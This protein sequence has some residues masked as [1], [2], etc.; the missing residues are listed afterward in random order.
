MF[1]PMAQGHG[2]TH[3]AQHIIMFSLLDSLSANKPHPPLKV[4][5]CISKWILKRIFILY[6]DLKHIDQIKVY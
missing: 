6:S 4:L 5:F 1:S 3:F 2:P